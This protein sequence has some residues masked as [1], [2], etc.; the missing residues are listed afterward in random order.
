MKIN[1]YRDK[2]DFFMLNDMME[3]KIKKIFKGGLQAHKKADLGPAWFAN[4]KPEDWHARA[5][6]VI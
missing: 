2:R 3:T 6:P 4:G 1:V 5:G